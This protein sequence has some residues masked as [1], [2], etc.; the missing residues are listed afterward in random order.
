MF[1]LP[2]FERYFLNALE[3]RLVLLLFGMLGMVFGDVALRWI[4]NAFGAAGLDSPLPGGIRSICR[5]RAA[6]SSPGA[7]I[8]LPTC[9][10]LSIRESRGLHP[11]SR[12]VGQ[13]LR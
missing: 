11:R 13:V 4:G 2:R 5:R 10:H 9:R 6:L 3:A 12:L 1:W 8:K 7:P